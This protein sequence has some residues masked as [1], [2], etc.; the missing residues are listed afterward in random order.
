MTLWV[1]LVL[2]V[3]AA[4][5][6]VM[7]PQ[8]RKR[9][10]AAA[11]RRDYDVAVYA[12]QLRE[13]KTDV[14][15]GVLSADEETQARL[16]IERRVLDADASRTIMG[17]QTGSPIF[18]A[19][20]ASLV[21]AFIPGFALGLYLWRGSPELPG[22]S[23]E[24]SPAAAAAPAQ[25]PEVGVSVEELA[26]RLREQPDNLDGW[27]LLG[28]SY[29]T[30]GRH[31]EA[32]RA[33]RQAVGLAPGDASVQ[34]RLGESMVMAT[35]GFVTPAAREI[36][37]AALGIEPRDLAALYYLALAA[38]QAGRLQEA[39]DGWRTLAREAPA[40][41]P[42]LGDVRERLVGLAG[43][44]GLDADEALA[45]VPAGP[46]PARTAARGPSQEDIAAAAEMTPEDRQAMIRSM[47]ERLAAR[48]EA[49]PNDAE[50]WLRLAQSY[51]VLGERDKAV[52]ARARAQ[53]ASAAQPAAPRGPSQEDIAAA[54]EMAPE[55]RQAMI[56]GMVERLAA[57][58]EADPSDGE[59]WLQLARSYEVLGE[60]EKA[61]EA[62][63]RGQAAASG[64]SDAA[65]RGPRQEDIAA[66]AEMAPE[67]RQS[68]IR[69]MVEGL[70]ARLAENPEDREGWLRLA[71]SYEV[72]GEYGRALDALAGAARRFPS[73]PDILAG[74]GKAL[75]E[76][77][78]P[79][80]PVPEAAVALYR[81]VLEVDGGHADALFITGLAEAQGGRA[82]E[83]IA[84]WRRLLA[85]LDP[86]SPARA[87]V[88]RRI[89]VLEA[90][91]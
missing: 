31:S 67:D 54:A 35:E 11:S 87:E 13:I 81:R 36:F 71:R 42:W 73:D 58:L 17:K 49:N 12:D 72:L 62:R 6:V 34:S 65:P 89:E 47:V 70:A 18:S 80:A 10:R 56:R 41:A 14:E 44:L 75:I 16:E 78:G 40:D 32:V 3:A 9:R 4:L 33:Y 19:I 61:A 8:L 2:M 25:V 59:G 28:R 88:S 85:V 55:D 26:A 39:F 20:G 50:G 91:Q 60:P 52:E 23:A 7:F 74:Y 77:A 51:E 29:I 83:A 15:R 76:D 53:T 79:G 63:A 1:V 84:V 68:M 64:T 69:G 27:L 82:G 66:A 90:G 37:E 30:L 38:A 86:A 22:Q 24:M 5:A 48:L 57:R 45:G 43:E 21:L 46:A